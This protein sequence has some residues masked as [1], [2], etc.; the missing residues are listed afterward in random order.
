MIS[1]K[2][3]LGSFYYLEQLTFYNKQFLEARDIKYVYVSFFRPWTMDHRVDDEAPID[4]G[5]VGRAYTEQDYEGHR[6]H[7]VFVGVHVP[8]SRRS[9]R[10]H[11]GTQRQ[12]SDKGGADADR[13]SK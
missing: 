8:G 9:H 3:Y 10:R 6:A 7:T 2:W 12:N 1:T 11:K 4:P 13:P 5:L